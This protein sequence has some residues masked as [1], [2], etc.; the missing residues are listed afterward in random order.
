MII[1]KELI[2]P[3]PIPATALAQYSQTL[4]WAKPANSPPRPK[5]NLVSAMVLA[6]EMTH[7]DASKIIFLPK[8]SDRRDVIIWKLVFATRNAVPAQVMDSA[9]SRSFPMI[10]RIVLTLVESMNEMSSEICRPNIRTSSRPRGSVADWSCGMTSRPIATCV[11][12]IYSVVDK[13]QT[14]LMHQPGHRMA[15]FRRAAR[16]VSWCKISA[17]TFPSDSYRDDSDDSSE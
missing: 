6:R 14:S 11:F 7:R 4:F 2:P 1:D 12:R 8:Q 5:K 9:A 15:S 17:E 13:S 10:G 16:S 3:P